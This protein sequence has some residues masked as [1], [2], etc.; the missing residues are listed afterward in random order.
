MKKRWNVISRGNRRTRKAIY[1][2]GTLSNTSP[3]WTDLSANTGL[4]GEK[5]VPD[6]LSCGTTTVKLTANS[7][8]RILPLYTK[9]I[10]IF[11]LSGSLYCPSG[12]TMT[13][14]TRHFCLQLTYSNCI[15]C[16]FQLRNFT[17]ES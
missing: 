7:A 8:R 10:T 11:R 4:H 17:E 2:I 14:K 16:F 15:S 3:T 5:P 13:L 9:N 1:A 12:E 6:G